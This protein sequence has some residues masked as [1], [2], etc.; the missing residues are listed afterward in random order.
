MQEIIEWLQTPEGEAW[1]SRCIHRVAFQC[2]YFGEV[3]ED[4]TDAHIR[5]SDVSDVRIKKD[6]GE[7]GWQQL[8]NSDSPPFPYIFPIE[9]KEDK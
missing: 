2:G 7:T 6:I 8:V 5:I 1:S 3:K 4:L 9:Y